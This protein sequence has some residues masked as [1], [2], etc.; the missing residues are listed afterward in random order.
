MVAVKYFLKCYLVLKSLY[1]LCLLVTPSNTFSLPQF[2][3]HQ[4][5]KCQT[6]AVGLPLKCCVFRYRGKNATTRVIKWD[7][8]SFKIRHALN[9]DLQDG[10]FCFWMDAGKGKNKRYMAADMDSSV[11]TTKG[12]GDRT[13]R[14]K[15]ES[16][17]SLSKRII[18]ICMKETEKF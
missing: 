12:I 13:V 2:S 3:N 15:P 10:A 11:P 14:F 1:F 16:T 6:Q 9:A 18:T 8:A 17:E 5:N 7:N 4:P